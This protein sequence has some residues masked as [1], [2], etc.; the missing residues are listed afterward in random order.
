MAILVVEDELDLSDLLSYILRRAGHDVIVAQ[1]GETALQMWRQKNP[2][3]VLLDIG[4]PKK[5]G[6]EV[7]K[8]I[9]HESSTPVIIVSGADTEDEMVQGFDL[10]AVDYVTKPFSPKLLHARVRT[11][12]RRSSGHEAHRS[13]DSALIV[14][15]LSLDSTWRT[16]TCGEEK[17]SLTKIEYQVLRELALS[18]GQVVSHAELIERVW[19]YKGEESSNIVKGHIRSLRL[20][21]TNIGSSTQIKIITAVGYMLEAPV[22]V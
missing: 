1:D 15:D 2:E 16:V 17:V 20:K 19:G 10:G 3:L 12:L 11:A 5:N 21:L 9:R 4:L 18:S 7:C 6:W 22:A 8:T 14:G 13:Q